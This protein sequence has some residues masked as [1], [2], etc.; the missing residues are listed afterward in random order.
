MCINVIKERDKPNRKKQEPNMKT[1]SPRKCEVTI[2]RP[3]GTIET[4]IHPKVDYMNNAMLKA[5]NKAMAA[6][7]KG[8]FVSYRNIDAVI[9]MEESDYMGPCTRCCETVDYRVAY[10]QLEWTRLGGQKVKVQAHYCEG[11]RRTLQAVGM[12]EKSAMEERAAEVPSYEPT[13]K[14]EADA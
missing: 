5:A 1:I 7:G 12:G 14:P 4:V 11:C 2:E 9:E 6:A 13:N 8:R 10:K 3:D